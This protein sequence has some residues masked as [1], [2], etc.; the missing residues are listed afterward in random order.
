M[1]REKE[2]KYDE[3]GKRGK[4]ERRTCLDSKKRDEE[5]EM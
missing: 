4:K 3:T 1:K 5:N 2:K